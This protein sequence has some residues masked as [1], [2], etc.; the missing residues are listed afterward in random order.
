MSQAATRNVNQARAVLLENGDETVVLGFNETSYR[1]HLIVLKRLGRE[2]GKRVKGV[3]R[4]TARRIDRIGT[5][6]KYVEPVYGPPRRVAGRIVALDA[7]ANTVTVDAGMPMVMKVGAPTQRATDF[8]V[9]D[10]VTMNVMP[11]A[12]FAPAV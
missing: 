7:E 2:E 12:T 8:A 10:F 11:G 9:G 5:G 1:M 3:I 6:G 4:A